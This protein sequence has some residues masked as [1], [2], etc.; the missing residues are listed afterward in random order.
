MPHDLPSPWAEFLAEID[1]SLPG[2]VQLHCSGGFVLTVCYGVPRVT[3]DVDCVRIV[4]RDQ[5]RV[6]QRMAGEDSQLARKHRVHLQYSAVATLPESYDTRL[7]EPFRGR[8]KKL[9]L[10]VLDP[11]DLVLSKLERNSPK[12]REDVAY[13]AKALSLD[14]AVLRERYQ[15]EFRPYLLAKHEWH[16]Q[17]LE[18]WIEAYFASPR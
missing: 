11:Y 1:N 8:F 2:P 13:L 3:G 5:V 17:T 9:R 12:D 4:P 15:R 16:D 10:F 6:L 7:T 18:M 14:P